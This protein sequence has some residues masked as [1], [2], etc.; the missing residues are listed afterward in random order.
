MRFEGD[1]LI[2]FQVPNRR[3]KFENGPTKVRK[4]NKMAN[5]YCDGYI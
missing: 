1:H 4:P 5:M 2:S 3:P